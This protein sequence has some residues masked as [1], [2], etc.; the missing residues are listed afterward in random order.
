MHMLPGTR[1][2]VLVVVAVC[3]QRPQERD[4]RLRPCAGRHAKPAEITQRPADVVAEKVTDA[5]AA[6]SVRG[7]HPWGRP[8]LGWSSGGARR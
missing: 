8:S 5:R 7:A 3:A 4:G 6:E 1:L 2:V